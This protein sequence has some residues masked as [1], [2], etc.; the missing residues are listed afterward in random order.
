MPVDLYMKERIGIERKKKLLMRREKKMEKKMNNS[1][2]LQL[3]AQIGKILSKVAFVFSIIGICGCFVGLL[4]N[5]FG[6]G[7]VFKIGGVTIY[8]LL[9]EFDAYNVKSISATL[10]AW[11]IV[12]IG[13]AV[14]AKFAELYFHNALMAGI[15][16][17]QVGA[18]ELRRLGILTMVIP[19]GCA[20]VAEVVQGILTGFMNVSVDGWMEF[21][22]DNEA[23]VVVGVMF[24]VG[25]FLCGYGAELLNSKKMSQE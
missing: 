22:F 3:I 7:K 24:I 11:L 23:S 20:V 4:S 1:R 9:A 10:V 15:P 6:S 13:Q 19:T 5:V 8:G 14:L 18:R 2:V 25:S 16:F 21:N 12:C 17:T